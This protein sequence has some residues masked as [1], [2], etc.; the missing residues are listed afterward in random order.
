MPPDFETLVEKHSAEIFAYLYRLTRDEAEAQ[1]CLQ[2]AFVRAYRAYARLERGANY[3][4]WLYRIAGNVTFTHLKRRNREHRRQTAL[5]ESVADD[6]GRPGEAALQREAL[7]ALA[8]AVEG[9]PPQQRA[10]LILRHYQ[11]LSY[12]EVAAALQC[13][14]AAARANV[15]QAVHRIRMEFRHVE[16]ER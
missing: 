6:A 11:S 8:D 16:E 3:R 7:A 13:S 12:R 2:E 5:S 14:E 15:Y 4:A 10:A 9:L 1:D